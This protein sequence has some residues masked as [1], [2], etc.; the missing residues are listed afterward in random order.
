[1]LL[2][3]H[4]QTRELAVTGGGA[5][6]TCT[7]QICMSHTHMSVSAY[8]TEYYA[9]LSI[10]VSFNRTQVYFNLNSKRVIV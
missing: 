9:L 8:S 2:R 4:A 10:A 5:L 7:S 3:R 1:M 6:H